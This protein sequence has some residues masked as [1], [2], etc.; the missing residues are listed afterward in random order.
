VSSFGDELR[1]E[2]ELRRISLREIAEATKINLR[3]LDA[4]ERNDFE[5][6]PGGIFNRGFVKAYAEFI[7][8]DA[9]AMVTAYIHEEQSQRGEERTS[10]GIDKRAR[11]S[12]VGPISQQI[13]S[14]PRFR[15]SPVLVLILV[16]GFLLLVLGGWWLIRTFGSDDT[17]PAE[18]VTES[19][20]EHGV[21]LTAFS[22]TPTDMPPGG[23]GGDDR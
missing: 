21:S 10:F 9:D 13:K 2:R 17:P 3:Y 19:Q 15:I 22:I 14:G 7:G 11:E 12:V 4:L 23:S 16:I 20:E 8:I 18:P 6:L 5:H 1:R